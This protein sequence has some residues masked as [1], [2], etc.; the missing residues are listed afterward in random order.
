MTAI[1]LEKYQGLWYEIAKYPFKWE[2]NCDISG[3]CTTC[4]NVTASYKSANGNLFIENS[5]EIRDKK[6]VRSGQGIAIDKFTFN[7]IFNDG[8]PNDGIVKYEIMYTDYVNYSVVT[9][10]KDKLWILCRRKQIT[11]DEY[12]K[13]LQII[14]KVG[15]NINKLILNEVD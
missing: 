7:V 5:C 11:E 14:N 6:I 9:S 1:N 15:Y 13:L 3:M 10:G 8:L 12:N 4:R 2:I